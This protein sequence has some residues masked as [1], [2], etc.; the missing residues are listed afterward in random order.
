LDTT[1]DEMIAQKLTITMTDP[2]TGT[3][4][5]DIF[6][7]L[8]GAFTVGTPFVPANKWIPPFTVTAG[9]TPLAAADTLVINYKP[10]I[11]DALIGGH[12]YPDKPNHKRVFYRI[13][14]NNHV[15][16]TVA[17]GSDMTVEAA[18]ADYFMVEAPTQMAGG[19]D[20]IAD[21]VDADYSEQ[22]WDVDSSVF[23]RIVG[24][25]LGI[26]KFA[27]PGI[28]STSVQKA[29]VAY[30]EAKNMQYRYEIPAATVTEDA[31]INYINDTLGRSDFAV[32]SM[33]SYGYVV[34]PDDVE[35]V[36][37]KLISLTGQI[38]GREARIAGDWDG[39]HK[40]QAGEDATLPAILD[41]PTG[42]V[43]LNEELLNPVGIGVIK[44]VSG[45]YILWGDRML[46]VDPTWKWKHQ[47][48][49][50]SYYE[51][52]LQEN[53][54]WITFSLNDPVSDKKA[55]AA[56]R[57][58]FYPEWQPK[59]ALVGDTFEQA[60]IIK[61]DGENNTKATRDAGDKNAKVSLA[62]ANTTERFII[63]I[64]KQGIF[65]NVS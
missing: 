9:A 21:L 42:E 10:F 16:I 20:G 12:L 55:L 45:N 33:P 34:D 40:A 43:I 46:Y 7:A 39:Y 6:G 22:G 14:D 24:R 52:I 58:L 63:T 8:P 35:N 36:K 64:G 5:S 3:V 31:A 62:L 61:I 18:I 30:A 48:E 23:N 1:T 32:V 56:M 47:R 49:Q 50:M 11:L 13:V 27:T 37:R 15:S 19:L 25:N 4:V 29:G 17:S 38:H 57:S 44:K 51:H 41:I 54:G 60:A 28:T 53:F 2:T 65:E 59:R 26:I